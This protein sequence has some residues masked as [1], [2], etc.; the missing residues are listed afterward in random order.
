MNLRGAGE[1]L[2]HWRGT[3][4]PLIAVGTLEQ[5]VVA[6]LYLVNMIGNVER[7]AQH[8]KGFAVSLP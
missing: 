5:M 2:G 6:D 1:A 3:L 8:T 7:V 4:E